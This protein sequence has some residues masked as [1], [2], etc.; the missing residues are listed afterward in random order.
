MVKSVQNTK[1]IIEDS[2]QS[3]FFESLDRFNNSLSIK[4]P[5]ET[6]YYSSYV[7]NKYSI[8]S[9]YFHSDG[10]GMREKV[11]GTGLLE[12]SS[13]SLIERKFKLKDI[14]D[15]S[16]CLLGVFSDSVN[17]KILNE[18]YYSKIGVTAYRQLNS[19][20]PSFMDVPDFYHELSNHFSEV[21]RFLSLF[22]RDFF[23]KNNQSPFETIFK[24]G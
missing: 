20:E 15:T 2:L 1:I 24:C 22:T 9:E 8:S 4:L 3:Y 13:L 16:L 21:V 10:D 18:N 12:A 5:I 23:K 11:L 17:K 14:G 7:L 19:L 6:I